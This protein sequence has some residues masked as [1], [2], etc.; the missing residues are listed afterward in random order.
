MWLAARV[1]NQLVGSGIGLL[2]G[3]YAV[4]SLLM[5]AW[6]AYLT[7]W[8]YYAAVSPE[9]MSEDRLVEAGPVLWLFV[10]FLAG[11]A[12]LFWAACRHLD[13]SEGGPA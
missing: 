5:P 2:G 8:G 7:P 10:P 1:D 9:A 3:F 13:R 11:A 12:A 6:A 4:F